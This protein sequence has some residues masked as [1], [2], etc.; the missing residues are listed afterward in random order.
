MPPTCNS[1]PQA[2]GH[3]RYAFAHVDICDEAAL[4]SLFDRYA[5]QAVI[6][7]AAESH[8]D[9]S[10]DGPADFIRT[11]I[12]GTFTLL[13]ETLRFWRGQD[14]ASRGSFRFLHVSTDEVYG[15]LGADGLFTETTAYRPNSPYSASKASSDHLV[16]AWRETYELPA[17]VTNCSNNYGPY[18]FPEKL[19]PHMIIRGLRGART[20]GL[21]R[22]SKR[23]RLAL[24]RGPR[25][26]FDKCSAAWPR[27]RD[28]QYRGAM[29]THKPRCRH[30]P[31][32]TSSTISHRATTVRVVASIKFVEDRPG[33][34]RR[35][36]IDATKLNVSSVG[37][38]KR[39]LKPELKKPSNGTLPNSA[40]G[41]Q[42]WRAD[43]KSEGSAR[44]SEAV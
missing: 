14:L 10:I 7:L 5:P 6:N 43:T 34:D 25:T 1:I 22:R 24:R 11:N 38:P 2:E 16:R 44:R 27:G 39:A 32:V 28:L 9:R 35:Y 29:R 40:G 18:Q 17:L 4:R 8:V 19:I 42:F 12:G 31:S 15:S 30:A 23:P 33:H 26:G 36:A 37:A 41:K 3:A 20:A 13:Q 21:W